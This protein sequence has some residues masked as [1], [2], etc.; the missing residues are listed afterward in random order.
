MRDKPEKRTDEFTSIGKAIGGDEAVNGPDLFLRK[1]Y[2]DCA[3]TKIIVANFVKVCQIHD[4][5]YLY[6]DTKQTKH[7]TLI[8]E[9]LYRVCFL[10][11]NN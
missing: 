1:R 8:C 7:V 3:H 5:N 10:H 6:T 4:E 9:C 11:I 2:I